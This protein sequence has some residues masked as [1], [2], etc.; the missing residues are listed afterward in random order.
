MYI[1]RSIASKLFLQLITS[2]SA[3]PVYMLDA[4]ALIWPVVGLCRGSVSF[5]VA[6]CIIIILWL[7]YYC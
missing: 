4:A 5:D 2:H 6:L 3:C 1:A 7:Q